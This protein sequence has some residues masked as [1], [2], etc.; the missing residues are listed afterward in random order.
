MEVKKTGKYKTRDGRTVEIYG[1]DDL[2]GGPMLAEGYFT[3]TRAMNWWEPNT[4]KN[5]A[6]EKAD[7]IERIEE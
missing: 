3:D 5:K 7:I 6:E 2:G 1:F 4:G